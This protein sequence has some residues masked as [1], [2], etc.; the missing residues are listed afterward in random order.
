MAERAKVLKDLSELT[1]TILQITMLMGL[2]PTGVVATRSPEGNNWRQFLDGFFCSH[3]FLM[4]GLHRYC[5][6]WFWR[7][8]DR[9]LCW[10]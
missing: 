6:F 3:S 2:G 1:K 4:V 7:R 9:R 10:K 8:L 5:N